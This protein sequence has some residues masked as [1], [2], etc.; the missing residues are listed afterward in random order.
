MGKVAHTVNYKCLLYK[1]FNLTT[2]FSISWVDVDYSN[3]NTDIA[4]ITS[5][6]L[7]N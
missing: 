5:I 6:K 4:I 2:F 1:H 3:Y 7:G